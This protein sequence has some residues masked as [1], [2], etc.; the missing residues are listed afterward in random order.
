MPWDISTSMLFTLSYDVMD[1]GISCLKPQNGNSVFVSFNFN[2]FESIQIVTSCRHSSKPMILSIL[3]TTGVKESL[4][5]GLS[6][7]P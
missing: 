7:K 5:V 3:S 1:F 4:T 6:G 2:L